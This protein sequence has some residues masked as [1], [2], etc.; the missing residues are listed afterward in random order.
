[1]PQGLVISQ[2][3]PAGKKVKQG[4][5]VKLL[6]SLGH[7]DLEV[8][9][10]RKLPLREAQR[11]AE[12]MGFRVEVEREYSDD[13]PVDTVVDQLPKPGEKSSAGKII[14]LFV[15]KGPEPHEIEMPNLIGKNIN[16]V[17]R[18]LAENDIPYGDIKSIRTNALE[19]GYVVSQSILPGA[20]VDSSTMDEVLVYI[21]EASDGTGQ[22]PDNGGLFPDDDPFS[23]GGAQDK[24]KKK[25][26]TVT[27]SQDA[28]EVVVVVIDRDTRTETYRGVH[29]SGDTVNLTVEGRG[30]VVVK[31]FI[32][33]QQEQ[34]TQF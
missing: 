33:G 2:D 3:P 12:D 10:L 4:R 34:Q 7:V 28:S 8:R 27:V 23:E 24:L 5:V 21:A 18:I 31:V 1:M 26:L 19:P 32:N 29:N 9:D 30:E 15:S 13:A 22:D 17:Y 11:L 25:A 14:K 16:D 6:V 20:M